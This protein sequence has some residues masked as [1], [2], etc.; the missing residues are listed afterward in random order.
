MIFATVGTQLPFDRLLLGLDSW[1]A[2]KPRCAGARPGRRKP[3]R[4]RHIETVAH[5]SQAEF[6]RPSSKPR[7]SSWP[8]PGWARSCRRRSWANR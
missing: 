6:P 1:A 3:R 7:V 5:L 4:L 8:T 2:A